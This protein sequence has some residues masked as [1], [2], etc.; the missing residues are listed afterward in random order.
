M[1]KIKMRQNVKLKNLFTF[2]DNFVYLNI[3]KTKTVLSA[4][5]VG[6]DNAI[7]FT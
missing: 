5:F 3:K 2:Y 6:F 7:F 1:Y 4:I